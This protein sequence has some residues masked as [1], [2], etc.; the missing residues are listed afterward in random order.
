L[1]DYGLQLS[2]KLG[3]GYDAH[4]INI[5]AADTAEFEAR[6]KWVAE[7]AAGIVSTAVA[8]EA[9]YGVKEIAGKI[10]SV[11]VSNHPQANNSGGESYAQPASGV[12]PGAQNTQTQAPGP[13]CGHGAMKYVKAGVSKA[14]RDYR[15]FWSCNGPRDS[16]CKTV[17]A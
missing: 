6:L 15:A 2:V 5:A 7:N 1:T 4:L 9:A 10:T 11:S 3:K 8:L 13:S 14:G 16:Q 17:D 12:Y